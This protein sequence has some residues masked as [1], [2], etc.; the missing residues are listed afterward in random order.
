MRIQSASPPPISEFRSTAIVSSPQM[1]TRTMV[2]SL[3]RRSG[4]IGHRSSGPQESF[5]AKAARRLGEPSRDPRKG[6]TR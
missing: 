6:L 3:A 5:C 1:M 4:L 2:A